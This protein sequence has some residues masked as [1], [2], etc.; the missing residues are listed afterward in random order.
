MGQKGKYMF[1]LNLSSF[2]PVQKAT[3][4]I[5]S[6]KLAIEKFPD[7]PAI[8]GMA[9]KLIQS[10]ENVVKAYSEW[11]T[12]NETIEVIKAD[13]KR[14]NAVKS[15][16]LALKSSMLE[17]DDSIVSRAGKVYDHLFPFKL[18]FI[19][20]PFGEESAWI[21]NIIQK[22][23]E[24]EQDIESLGFTQKVTNLKMFQEAFDRVYSA[25]S[26]F[27]E[28]KPEK[29]RRIVG[30]MDQMIRSM[31]N[32][33]DAVFPEN[34]R[35]SVLDPLIRLSNAIRTKTAPANPTEV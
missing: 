29:V 10:S 2:S 15:L 16:A 25:R 22:T 32:Y 35:D 23:T 11:T 13:E 9:E 8:K 21:K 30:P 3:A 33:I 27:M 19:R 26:D 18:D 17:D 12:R 4:A 24:I 34:Q 20:A 6:A 31:I 14:D 28:T 5:A 1:S 7:D